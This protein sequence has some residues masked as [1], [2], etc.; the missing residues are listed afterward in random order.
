MTAMLHQ[1]T[2]PQPEL[3]LIFW[4]G[5]VVRQFCIHTIHTVNRVTVVNR[6]FFCDG[7]DRCD[8]TKMPVKTAFCGMSLTKS[9]A[10]SCEENPTLSASPLAFIE[11]SAIHIVKLVPGPGRLCSWRPDRVG[12]GGVLERRL[13]HGKYACRWAPR[14]IDKR[15]FQLCHQRWSACLLSCAMRPLVSDKKP[16]EGWI[17]VHPSSASRLERDAL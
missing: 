6:R 14:F 2:L 16:G 1:E 8:T 12:Y 9:F 10:K 11:L 4:Q 17:T 7:C 15:N 13:A 5:E 3:Q